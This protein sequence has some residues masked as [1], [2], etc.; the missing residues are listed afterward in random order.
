L[1]ALNNKEVLKNNSSNYRNEI[2]IHKSLIQEGRREG[3]KR[4]FAS[5]KRNKS[6][7]RKI[8]IKGKRAN[9]RN[10]WTK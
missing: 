6:Y 10:I 2:E 1:K 4:Y 5:K 7:S 3:E 8:R 9:S